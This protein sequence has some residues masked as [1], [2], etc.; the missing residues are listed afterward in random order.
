MRDEAL[1]LLRLLA[2]G[3]SAEQF[4]GVASD[5]YAVGLAARA[6][7]RIEDLRG[8]E[9][10]L[11]ALIDTARDLA[12]AT[13]PDGVLDA[14]VRRARALLGTDV[15]YLT[16]YDPDRGDTYMR[17]TDGAVAAS[18]RILRLDLGVGL[19]GLVA[20]TREA[21]WTSDY[22][23]DSRFAHTETI[24]SGVGD[25]GL[26]AICGTP[27]LVEDEFVGVLFA[28]NRRRHT[29]TPDEVALLGSL[30]ALA[31]ITI[32]QMRGH[33]ATKEAL[34]ELSL[35]HEAERRHTA[36]VER[37]AEA[38]D[39][40]TRIVASGGGVDD[41]TKALVEV[42]GGWTVLLDEEG[43]RISEHGPVPGAQLAPGSSDPLWRSA[44]VRSARSESRGVE[45]DGSYAVAVRA[46]REVLSVLV[47]GG[48]EL[49]E[50]GWRIIERAG[51]VIS[52]ILLSQ[53][54]M[55]AAR[56]Q[57]LS[58]HVADLVTGSMAMSEAAL[59]FRR[60]GLS[61]G[62][63]FCLVAVRGSDQSGSSL[64]K[65]IGTRMAGRGFA[66][67]YGK[68]VVALVGGDDPGAIAERLV[69][70]LRPLG[71][72]T[73]AGVG[74]LA[75]VD[76]IPDAYG[77]AVRTLDAMIA[78]GRHGEGA[79]T[80]DLGFAGLVVGSAPD[81]HAY[82][83]QVLGPLVHYDRSRGTNLLGTV[84]A[85]FACGRSQRRAAERLNVHVNTVVQRLERV[86]QLLGS[87]WDE[88]DPSL[89]IQLALRMRRLLPAPGRRQRS[90]GLRPGGT[91]LRGGPAL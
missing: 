30:A 28:S 25:E 85:Y 14:I 32:K 77:E 59:L 79:A 74:P 55:A 3:A 87:S 10:A 64:A 9:R 54:D 26:V 29:F 50:L 72:V 12:A 62:Q 21:W 56:Q 33:H 51:A 11:R 57:A 89:E 86:E 73:A 18:F 19:G 81:V 36:E 27:L 43:R 23:I 37:S 13:E 91:P 20:A 45:I 78:L 41:L 58:D 49:T 5:P 6:A 31:A 83:T 34:H 2:D 80:A 71:D 61:T 15:A 68:T 82:V 42:L 4:D 84:E 76:G 65:V 88:P 7:R 22:R 90:S 75:S 1:E 52:L 40:F 66:G 8:R 60:E 38:H 35:A 69:H 67:E 63:P 16:L 46:R 70:Q 44:V 53:R 47:C 17:A 24:D 48:Q 39:R